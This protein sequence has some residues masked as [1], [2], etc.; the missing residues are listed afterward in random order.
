MDEFKE[1]TM[2]K[3]NSNA[4]FVKENQKTNY[5]LLHNFKC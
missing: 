5:I 2:D 4:Y 3:T 1:E